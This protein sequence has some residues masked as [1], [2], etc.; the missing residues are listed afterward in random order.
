MKSNNEIRFYNYIIQKKYF[1][2]ILIGQTL[3]IGLKGKF[4]LDFLCIKKLNN[5]IYRIAIEIDGEQHYV[6][7]TF[8]N[9]ANS[10]LHIK[11]DVLKNNYFFNNNYFSFIRLKE[12]ND[13][14]IYDQIFQTC[15]Y[16]LKKVIYMSAKR[17]ITSWIH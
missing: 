15:F 1:D 17:T 10:N 9:K 11:R 12:H 8:Y 6:K 14:S 7:N 2:G 4:S 3:P 13:F 16:T 5:K